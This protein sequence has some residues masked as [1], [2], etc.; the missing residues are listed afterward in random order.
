MRRKYFIVFACISVFLISSILQFPA[1][2]AAGSE[3]DW[4]S[5]YG[6]N[7]DNT[8][9]T[10]SK[11][12]RSSQLLWKYN[13]GTQVRSSAA[14]VDGVVY[15]G[16]FDGSVYAIN[17][18]MGVQIWKVKIGTKVWASPA[19]VNGRVYIGNMEN[20]FY[21]LN[22]YT[23]ETIW[24]FTNG[25]GMF[26][27][28]T[29][30]GGVVYQASTDG[31][32]YALD[33]TSGGLKWSFKAIGE[34]RCTPS[35]VNGVVY[36]GSNGAASGAIYA[37][38]A[39]DGS[40]LWS[41]AT[42]PGASSYQDSSP[43]VKG[44]VVFIGASDGNLYAIEASSGVMKWSFKT[45]GKVS[46]SPAVFQGVVY[47]G[48]EDGKVYALNYSTGTKIWEN[49]VGWPVYSS[50][51][52]ADGVVYI[53]SYGSSLVLALDSLSGSLI[54]SYS[55]GFVFASPAIAN[56][57]V[58]VGTYDNLLYAF[59]APDGR[60]WGTDFNYLDLN[61]MALEG[62][63]LTRPLGT[64][65]VPGGGVILDASP[66]LTEIGYYQGIPLDIYDWKVDVK[67]I[68]LGVGHSGINVK[69]ITERHTYIWMV[70][71]EKSQYQFVRDNVS[72]F[73]IDGYSEKSNENVYLTIEKNSGNIGLYANGKFVKSYVEQDTLLSRVTGVSF[74]SGGWAGSR[75][76]YMYVG[77]FVPQAK[78][79]PDINL[80]LTQYSINVTII[81][82]GSIIKTPTKSLYNAGESVTLLA[83][84]SQGYNFSRWT[85][86]QLG[87]T[88]P[89]TIIMN[90]NK[91]ITATFTKKQSTN[92]TIITTKIENG[93][94]I[95]SSRVTLDFKDQNPTTK[96]YEVKVDGGAWTNVGTTTSYTAS[97]LSLGE[98][99]IEV[100]AIDN[101]G[102]I[103][104]S[105]K[106]DFAVSVWVPPANNA[107]A[108]SVA[109]VSTIG[110]I[111][112]I[113][114]A[115]SN[116]LNMPLSWLWEKLNS[117]LPDSVKGWLES[118][119]SSKRQ[120]VIE[121]KTGSIFTLSRIEIIA[122]IAALA[123]M[124]FAFAY[125]GAGT[126]ED[127]ILL[128]PT[129]LAT[130]VIVG[131]TK[132]LITELYARTLG[133]WA[134]HRLWYLGLTT[135]LASTIIFRT[136]FSSPSR[137]VNH[138]PSFTSRSQGLVA[139]ASIVI[140]LVFGA[141]FYALLVAGFS[142]IGSIGLGM[143][144][145][146]ALFDAIPITPMNGRDIYDWN[147]PIWAAQFILTL[148]LYS[149][150]LLYI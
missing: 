9:V 38:R 47:V 136:P 144:I 107:V 1:S 20:G 95:A 3:V 99:S 13:T 59:G 72:I 12:P 18:N 114:T 6:H 149:A 14:V 24:T 32:I 84:P 40:K 98:H 58:Y 36:F 132:N 34:I 130:S 79:F 5:S 108:S 89:M 43:A 85:G 118:F 65:L 54:W 109:I 91:T 125:S 61:E 31:T 102:V 42:G 83:I 68:W 4:W 128:I 28:P 126:I 76:K 138:S 139:S 17:A 53:G 140:S 51:S 146:G 62:W 70:N 119:I 15:C 123:A 148:V 143:C 127:F 116:P 77:A 75:V 134:E 48:S 141:V 122:Y 16:G 115:I 103:T 80:P 45:G 29:V 96:S 26:N 41:L 87:N 64:S 106:V 92:T 44:G 88:N 94:T 67:G 81:R 105:K 82:D 71:G 52:L 7:L 25:T 66:G 69:L 113:A 86:D 33:E 78:V 35:V 104:D 37:L 117:L 110:V 55:A 135:F 46:S 121:H 63:T 142:Y 23:G 57:V 150:W 2:S 74:N 19:V 10:T 100:R 56:G 11:G 101:T 145:L 147:K 73:N 137:I 97:G 27:G 50:P 129:V 131:V 30:T 112:V 90:A 39:A 133:V 22:A 93:T 120:L 49:N 111:S 60:A 124:T 8:R 21:A